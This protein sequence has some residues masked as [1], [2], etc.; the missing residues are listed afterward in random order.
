MIEAVYAVNFCKVDLQRNQ[1]Y[2]LVGA[3][4]LARHTGNMLAFHHTLTHLCTP[5]GAKHVLQCAF[6]DHIRAFT[7]QKGSYQSLSNSGWLAPTL[8]L[9]PQAAAL[10]LTYLNI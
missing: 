2:R 7:L 3:C 9:K 6:M 1:V 8:L 5:L 10:A 4:G